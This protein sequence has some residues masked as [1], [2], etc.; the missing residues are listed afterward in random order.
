MKLIAECFKCPKGGPEVKLCAHCRTPQGAGVY[1]AHLVEALLD[2]YEPA[3]FRGGGKAGRTILTKCQT[4]KVMSDLAE[5][6]KAPEIAKELRVSPGV[7]YRLK[8][9][10]AGE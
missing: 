7:I 4:E 2:G 6:K 1:K 5:G 10:E 9:R 8:G 3:K